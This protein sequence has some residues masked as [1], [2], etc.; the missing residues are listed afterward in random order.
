M[1]KLKR[2]L[3]LIVLLV[4]SVGLVS[5][6][7]PVEEV[8]AAPAEPV[9]PE[10]IK[11]L[12]EIRD[13]LEFDIAS[14]GYFAVMVDVVGKKGERENYTIYRIPLLLCLRF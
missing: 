4:V 1:T 12:T 10:D 13:L 11:L 5:C 2:Y 14:S 7:E 6:K 3:L 9:I 8:P